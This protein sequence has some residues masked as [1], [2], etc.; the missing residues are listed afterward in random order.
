[1]TMSLSMPVA[2]DRRSRAQLAIVVLGVLLLAT[3][4]GSLCVGPSGLSTGE[5][6][7]LIAD[8]LAGRF[9]A[10]GSTSHVILF[11]IRIPRTLLGALVG[12]S[13][14][15]AGAMM[16]G[17]FRNPLA[18]PGLVGVSSGAALGAVLVIVL[19]SALIAPITGIVRIGALPIAAFVGGFATT[20]TLYGIATREGRTSVGTMLLA[21]IA[22]GA[23]A[24]ALTSYLVFR[25]DD[26]QL[27]ELT[28]WSMGSLGGA[29][30][31]KILIATPPIIAV[32]ALMPFCA[33]GLDALVLGESEA[34]HLGIDTQRLKSIVIFAT[35]LAVGVAVAFAGVIGFVGIVVP[36][37][38]RLA[39]GPEHRTLLPASALLGAAL[40]IAADMVCRVIVAPAE[41]PIGIVT[42][43][44]G[45]PFFLSILLRKRGVVDL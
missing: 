22:L 25:S 31:P 23:L 6:G 13:L 18:D 9:D 4:I 37:V 11:D 36:H 32:L 1:M 41:L 8:A 28:F 39:I 14:A 3:M 43:T 29:T 30:W 33:R 15:V 45:A 27:R 24:A 17:L 7:Q 34:R 42:A 26:L 38:L 16:Q 5:V 20:L 12:A 19:G 2:G 40:L 35:A 21:G 10:V 44:I